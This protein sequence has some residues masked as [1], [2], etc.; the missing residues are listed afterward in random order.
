MNC[1]ECGLPIGDKILGPR[2]EGCIERRARA[3]LLQH[4]KLF[5]PQ[6]LQGSHALSITHLGDLVW[7][8]VLIG[9]RYHAYCGQSVGPGWQIK[10]VTLDQWPPRM[11]HLCK[12]V[13]DRLLEEVRAEVA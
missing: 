2:C 12:E 7:H 5:L 1:R 3:A 10:R 11:C 8:V 13:F 4:Q 9:D 6:V